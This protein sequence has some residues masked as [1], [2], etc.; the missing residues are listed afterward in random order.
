MAGPGSL[1]TDRRVGTGDFDG[2]DGAVSGATVASS[3][4]RIDDARFRHPR[5]GGPTWSPAP[6][7]ADRDP[8]VTMYLPNSGLQPAGAE[9]GEFIEADEA[10]EPGDRRGAGMESRDR[11]TVHLDT[12]SLIDITRWAEEYITDVVA[13]H[14]G[15]R[16]DVRAVVHELHYQVNV[17][18]A[19]TEAPL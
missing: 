12:Q 18:E 17:L 7:I 19:D 14:H 2:G 1:P 5:R 10:V 11:P 9:P 13:N 3:T 15:D 8:V 6:D 4:G 16:N